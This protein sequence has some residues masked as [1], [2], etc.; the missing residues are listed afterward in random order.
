MKQ[1][2]VS[3]L[4]KMTV[5]GKYRNLYGSDHDLALLIQSRLDLLKYSK[6]TQNIS[7][8]F[9]KTKYIF[10]LVGLLNTKEKPFII[11]YYQEQ[12]SR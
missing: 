7:V 4:T 6:T 9:Q 10:F 2:L 1:C 12:T 11:F 3:Y 5:K 8:C